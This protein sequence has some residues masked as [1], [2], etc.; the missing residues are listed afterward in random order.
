MSLL[1]IKDLAALLIGLPEFRP[2]IFNDYCLFFHWQYFKF[3]KKNKIKNKKKFASRRS[4]LSKFSW[5]YLAYVA[6]GHWRLSGHSLLLYGF[7]KIVKGL[8]G[9]SF[10]FKIIWTYFAYVT[11]SHW[12]LIKQQSWWFVIGDV[13]LRSTPTLIWIYFAYIAINHLKLDS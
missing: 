5:I 6:V 1:A 2:Q 12:R 9:L 10:T 11:I 3:K 13:G 8:E 4:T 7:V